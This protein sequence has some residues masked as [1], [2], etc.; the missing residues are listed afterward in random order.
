MDSM[1]LIDRKRPQ[2]IDL[3]D[4]TQFNSWRLQFHPRGFAL[5]LP[6]TRSRSPIRRLAPIAWL[7]SLRSPRY[8]KHRAS[9]YLACS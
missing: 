8:R 7:A 4:I 6:Y 2:V 5:G 3:R 1:E 9:N